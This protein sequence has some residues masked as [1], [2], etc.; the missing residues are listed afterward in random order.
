MI[1]WGFVLFIF[2]SCLSA[3]FSG[4][5]T[6]FYRVTRVRLVIDALAGDRIA[7]AL[8]RLTNHP[9]LFVATALIGNNIA[10]Y[11]VSL[12]TVLLTQTIIGHSYFVELL[13]AIV[14]APV[15]FIYGELLP[16]NL[17]YQA[18][19]S[20]L[21]RTGPLFL[22]F[23]I[24]LFP[25]A[26][27]LWLFG[28]GLQKLI[29]ESPERVRL[30]LARNELS[31]VLDEGHH[32]GI[33]RP[34]QRRLAQ[35]LFQLANEPAARFAIAFA[36]VVSIRRGASKGEAFRLA[37]R[38]R[39]AAL[40]VHEITGGRRKLVG[41]VRVLDLHL[42]RGDSVDRVR[43]LL[44]IS[45]RETQIAALIRLQNAG[46]MLARLVDDAGQTVGVL[47]TRQLTEPL[48]RTTFVAHA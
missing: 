8:L 11:L 47:D 24:I 22:L 41:Y 31:R 42:D 30:A 38:H 45:T 3:F 25:I 40:P 9:A 23:T 33:L 16:K 48:F 17:F 2:G 14:M 20:M 13:V 10:N 5:E 35:G 21:R 6:G 39:L 32:A 36:R 46:E 28:R 7:A 12:S 37:R 44:E 19:N 4:S 15:L 1:L 18:P 34:A 29:G 43:P 26:L 27:L